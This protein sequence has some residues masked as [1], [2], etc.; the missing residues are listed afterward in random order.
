MSANRNASLDALRVLS[1]AGIITLHVAGGGFNDNKPLGF[2][3]DELSRFAVPAFFILSAYFWKPE[4]LA[5][6][7][8]LTLRVASRVLPA[9][10][11]W[12]AVFVLL[13]QV[14]YPDRSAIDYSPGGLMLLLWTGGPA[15][16]L[17]FLP[18]LV[19]AT[20]MVGFAGRAIGWRLTL[21]LSLLLFVG[22]TLVGAYARPLFGHGFP[23]WMDRNGL[24]FGPVFLTI[25]VLMRR[26]RDRVATVPFWAV[27]A[28][29]LGFGV[30]Q[31]AEGFIVVGRYPMGHD[32]SLATLGYAV[33][34]VLL[35]TRL[36]LHGRVWSSLGRATF[37]AYL[38]HPL[39][40]NWLGANLHGG[41][42]GLVIV[43]CF[44][45]T[46]SIGLA[47]VGVRAALEAKQK[48]RV[49]AGPSGL[50]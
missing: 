32:Y 45:I 5:A 3:L 47:W 48:A 34:V 9:F 16:H 36:E 39:V 15:F 6:P 20:A 35:F 4:E 8:R 13:R 44:A 27:V 7:W 11:I 1:L 50:L 2:V 33:A 18:A 49:T 25:G 37:A 24:F 12:T 41:S 31:V 26:H 40:L 21:T 38:M 43:L 23:F 19:L 14:Q 28:A 17:W 22:G 30:L 42:S 46:L 29:V 10:L